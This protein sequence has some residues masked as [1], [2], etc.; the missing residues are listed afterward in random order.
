MGHFEDLLLPFLT[1][2]CTRVLS[3]W[4][5]DCTGVRWTVSRAD[6]CRHCHALASERQNAIGIYSKTTRSDTLAICS[7]L[8]PVPPLRTI[9]VWGRGRELIA[10][11]GLTR[12]LACLTCDAGASCFRCRI[13]E[14]IKKGRYSHAAV[15]LVEPHA[16]GKC[17]TLRFTTV[18]NCNETEL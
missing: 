2:V 10:A 3:L 1:F 9:A 15:D 7:G 5:S 6:E 18:P 17:F 11:V 16:T 8:S 13:T 12:N 14:Q 4:S